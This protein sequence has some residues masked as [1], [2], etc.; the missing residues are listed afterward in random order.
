[1]IKNDYLIAGHRVRVEGDTLAPKV[2]RLPGFDVFRVTPEGEPVCTFKEG[3][4]NESLRESHD[5]IAKLPDIKEVLQTTDSDLADSSFA[6]KKDGSYLVVSYSNQEDAVLMV[7]ISADGRE[8]LFSG[9]MPGYLLKYACWVA[10]GIATVRSLTVAIHASTIL[11][12]EKAILVLGE[13]GTGK[14]THTRLWRENILGASLL[15]DDSPILRIE[16]DKVMA[17]G[18][19]WSGKMNC[20]VREGYPLAACIRLSQAPHN[21]IRRLNVHAAFAALHP[22]CPPPFAYDNRLYDSIVEFLSKLLTDVPVY[23]IEAL[24]DAEAAFLSRNTIF[25][26]CPEI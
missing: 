15:N 12:K 20:Y 10:Y 22:S 5:S 16:D 11:Y 18:S 2:D 7:E 17:Y 26:S 8:S 13:S 14:S 23:H 19:P 25:G 21:K 3:V 1:M 6:V 24:P 4:F 9:D